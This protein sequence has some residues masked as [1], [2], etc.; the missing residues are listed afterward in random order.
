MIAAI[1]QARLSSTRL[2]GK[3]LMDIEGKPM[4]LRVIDQVAQALLVEDVIIAT[5]VNSTAIVSFIREIGDGKSH[6]YIKKKDGIKCFC[7][8]ENDVL[9]R[10]FEIATILSCSII[11]RITSDCPLIDPEVIDKTIKKYL[12]NSYDYVSTVGTY[13]DGLDVEVF[14]YKTLKQAWEEA[15]NPYDREHVTPYIRNHPKIFKIGQ[16]ES[17]QDF[18]NLKLSVDTIKDLE[19]VRKIYK[20]LG[21]NFYLKDVLKLLGRETA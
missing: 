19:F 13:P 9:E 4:L 3:V 2:P 16:L 6:S 5:S 11:V 18:S 20:G 21:N 7:G 1:I 8:S 17:G 14:S 10:Y 12:D 15:T